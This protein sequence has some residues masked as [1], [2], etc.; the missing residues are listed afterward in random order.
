VRGEEIM[1]HRRT[2]KRRH[3]Q[4]SSSPIRDA[5]GTVT[6]AV[7]IIHDI[8]DRK[9]AEQ[10]VERA[11]EEW[12]RTFDSV[13]DLIAIFDDQHRVVRMNRA[14]AERL[15]LSTDQCLGRACHEYLHGLA[16]RPDYCPYIRTMQDQ[17]EHTVEVY[18]ERLGGY[19]LVTTCPLF[20]E[21][22]MIGAVQV[23]R[24]INAVKHAEA[25][26]RK[27]NAG[28]E[29][30]VAARTSDLT[31]TIN[32]LEAETQERAQAEA[33]LSL[34]NQHLRSL[35]L[36]L[37]RAEAQERQRLSQVLHDHLQQLIVSAGFNIEFVGD[38]LTDPELR[39]AVAG[40]GE[41]LLEATEECRNLAVELAPPILRGGL[42]AALPWLAKWMERR[43]GLSVRL[44]MDP[45]AE[46]ED[47]DVVVLLFQS[48]RE[49]LF[50]VVKHAGVR[51]AALIVSRP[52]SDRL[53]IEIAD[54]GAGFDS[55]RQD[56]NSGA[57]AGPTGLGLFSIRDRLKLLGG[58][59]DI[60]SAPGHGT[61]IVL[62]LPLAAKATR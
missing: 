6:G 30:R 9:L 37:T 11:K 26:L 52:D 23:S 15:G 55:T 51:E 39:N 40:A 27:I 47:P 59:V 25:E 5:E 14:M 34:A 7:A 56:A 20:H 12:E 21:G 45:G 29:S 58:Q 16:E 50:N 28:L 36:E 48:M 18:E 54:Q 8:T 31:K 4:Y 2:G 49:A 10:A 61:N 44:H 1:L 62:T 32:R 17:K 42:T 33:A 57:A 35:T 19:F 53:R 43:H 60:L 46:P 41:A 13:P 22:R 24:D 3:R 38:R